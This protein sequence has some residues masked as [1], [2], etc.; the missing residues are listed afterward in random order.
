MSNVDDERRKR[1]GGEG[2]FNC[3]PCLA[4]DLGD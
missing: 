1:W 2:V 4:S 3:R